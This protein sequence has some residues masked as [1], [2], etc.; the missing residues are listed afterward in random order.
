MARH[1]AH[2]LFR[3]KLFFDTA[4]DSPVSVKRL[5]RLFE[6]RSSPYKM[7]AVHYIWEDLFWTR[8]HERIPWL[9]SLIR[10]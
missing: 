7:L 3:S 8:R 2:E 5:L 4:P 10:L 6:K 1:A 9:E